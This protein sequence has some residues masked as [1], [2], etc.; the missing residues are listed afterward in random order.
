VCGTVLQISLGV[1]IK[2]GET[3]GKYSTHRE[4]RYGKK[5]TF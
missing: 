3:D 5:I 1:Q 2:K 4:I